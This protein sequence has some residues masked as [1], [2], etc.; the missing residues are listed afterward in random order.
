MYAELL[1][2][3]SKKIARC[4][5]TLAEEDEEDHLDSLPSVPIRELVLSLDPDLDLAS[6]VGKVPPNQVEHG[7]ALRVGED[8]EELDEEEWDEDEPGFEDSLL[9]PGSRTQDVKLQLRLLAQEPHRL[10]HFLENGKVTVD[11]RHLVR[12]LK[13]TELEDVITSRFGT[14]ALRLVRILLEKGKLD[15]KQISNLA[16]VRQKDIRV[17]LTA[18]H[19][20]GFL[21][22]QEVPRDNSRN[23]SRTMFLWFFDPERCRQMVLEDMYKTMARLLQRA[24][25]EREYMR[26]LLDKAQRT[27]VVG[28][29]EIYLSQE[30]QR[31]LRATLE[32][33]EKLLGQVMRLDRQVELLR[34]F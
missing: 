33:E 27:D 10:V 6:A 15:E 21:E 32:E 17:T 25:S 11:F 4:H 18:M 9:P 16:L 3:L 19:Q 1:N 14:L 26:P 24:A 29:E 23:A 13:E 12:Q 20:A 8:D 31:A 7:S 2:L 34:D 22:L 5:D 28:K 30:E